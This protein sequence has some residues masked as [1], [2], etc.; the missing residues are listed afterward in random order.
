[1]TVAVSCNLSDGVIL[2]VDSAVTVTT[3]Q[4]I[5]KVYENAEKLFQLG[6]RPI[7]VATY[8]LGAIGGRGIGSQLRE[9]E[10][11]DP[12]GIVRGQTGMSDVAET[13]RDFFMLSYVRDVVPALEAELGKKFSE[14]A[15]EQIPVLGLVV[16][17]FSYGAYLSEVWEIILPQHS[18][19]GSAVCR[20]GQGNFGSDWFA[21]FDPIRRYIKGF[22]PR[23]LDE[24]AGYFVNLLGRPLTSTENSQVG[25]VLQKYE[26]SVPFAAMPMDEGISY[27][28]FLVELAINH[29]RF[30]VGAPVVGGR[31]TIGKVSYRGE[32]FQILES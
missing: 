10:V 1:M 2:G 8:G 5:A 30:A 25:L 15:P 11:T 31:M 4:G 13:I 16:G 3:P 23:L 7:G 22:D 21:T 19:Q 28:K 17:G 6:E 9:L 20:R 32:R 14:L 27:T 18:T 29:H 12:N 26:Y 24:V